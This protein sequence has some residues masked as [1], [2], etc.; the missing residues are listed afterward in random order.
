M[1]VKKD[2]Q[3]GVV[4]LMFGN[5]CASIWTTAPDGYVPQIE[6]TT[7]SEWRNDGTDSTYVELA[8]AMLHSGALSTQQCCYI[9][10]WIDNERANY[11][12]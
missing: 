11:A 1:H 3:D 12:R 2:C 5:V 4:M 9:R 6:V 10:E 8:E 7:K